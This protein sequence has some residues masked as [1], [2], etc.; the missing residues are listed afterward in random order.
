MKKSNV[1]LGKEFEEKCIPILKKTFDKVLYLGKY[2]KTFDFECYK[3][4]KKYNVEVKFSEGM[5]ITFYPKQLKADILLLSLKGNFFVFNKYY[6][7]KIIL[8]E[9]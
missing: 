6:K 9:T 8:G 4:G 2:R 3:D 5:H 1:Q 7:D